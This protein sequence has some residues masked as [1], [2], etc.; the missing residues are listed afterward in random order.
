MDLSKLLLGFVK[1]EE[2]LHAM[3]RNVVTGGGCECDKAIYGKIMFDH[4]AIINIAVVLMLI[5]KIII[6]NII[7]LK[8]MTKIT[9]TMKTIMIIIV[10]IH[11]IPLS[12]SYSLSSNRH[13]IQL[14][15]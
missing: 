7:T 9:L 6:T 14:T 5:L 1:V 2:M 12:S 4:I 10:G 13:K 15:F 11:Y 3:Q 8:I